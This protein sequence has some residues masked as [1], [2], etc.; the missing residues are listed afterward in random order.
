[1][2]GS[3]CVGC[4]SL[5]IDTNANCSTDRPRET[6]A[7][8]HQHPS[9]THDRTFALGLVPKRQLHWSRRWKVEFQRSGSWGQVGQLC[10]TCSQEHWLDTYLLWNRYEWPLCQWC[11]V[12]NRMHYCMDAAWYHGDRPLWSHVKFMPC[13]AM[14]C[15][16]MYTRKRPCHAN[17][18]VIKKGTCKHL[19][20]LDSHIPQTPPEL[21]PTIL[22]VLRVWAELLQTQV[23]HHWCHLIGPQIF[24]S[25]KVDEWMCGFICHRVRSV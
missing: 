19:S 5:E 22:C 25:D 14:S 11:D 21:P 13:R 8:I 23:L 20:A 15:T 17:V 24:K 2:L 16:I 4:K 9:S 1:M 7:L 18:S 12:F 3:P 6:S 10:I